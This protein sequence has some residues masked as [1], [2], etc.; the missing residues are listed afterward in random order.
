MPDYSDRRRQPLGKHRELFLQ[1]KA[2]RALSESEER[3]R[4]LV[5]LAPEAIVLL[6]PVS[7]HLVEAN[8]KAEEIFGCTRDELLSVALPQFYATDQPDKV[9]VS[10]SLPEHTRR[11]LAGEEV[12]F[13]RAIISAKGEQRY[14]EVRLTEFP[15]GERQL[16]LG[17]FIDISLRKRA[18]ESLKRQVRFN[19]LVTRHLTRFSSCVASEVDVCVTEALR[20]LAEFV[21]V[22]HAHVIMI[23]A[24]RKTW[25]ITHEWCGPGVQRQF[26]TYHNVPFGSIPWSESRILSGQPIRINTLDDYPPGAPERHGTDTKAG[27]TSVLLVPIRGPTGLITGAVGMDSHCGVIV[28]SADDVAHCEM[29][30]NAI[31]GVLERKNAEEL[32]RKSEEKFSK[33][34]EADPTITCILRLQ[35]RKYL[36]V[37]QA[38]ERR[39]GYSREEVIGRTG[40]DLGLWVNV[41]DR[42]VAFQRIVADRSVRGLEG[43]FRTKTKEPVVALLS[44]EIIEFEGEECVLVVAED[45]TERKRTEQAL[46][47]SE[48]RFRV[49]SDSAPVMM[50]MANPEKACTDFN[51]GWLE[52]TG[53][54][55]WQELGDG[56]TE[57]VHPA[58]LEKCART[59]IAAF[60]ERQRFT[61][62]Y[63][64]RRHD[65]VYRWI[66][67]TGVPRF[68][69]DGSF[70]GYIGCCI[71]INDQREAEKVRLEFAGRLMAAQEAERTRIAR[72]LH[73]SIG[74]SIAL[75]GIQMQR[76]DRPVSGASD[77]SHP[78]V[79]ALSGKL[80]EIGT[81]VSQLSHQLH[82]SELEFLGL[83]VAVKS[84]CRE[85][86]E[87]YQIAVNCLCISVP[88]KLDNDISLCF[89]RVTQEALHN[90]AK[91]SH[92]AR[93]Q[94]L[95]VGTSSR[96]ML[97]IRDDGMGFDV[98]RL[99][100]AAGLGLI[101]MRERLHLI[102]G[103][104]AISSEPAHGTRIEAH[105]P[106]NAIAI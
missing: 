6:D 32:L 21:G 56:W 67:D 4:T 82:S 91:H 11:V 86:S 8:R 53:R 10:E 87:E 90:I 25:S 100:P 37:N 79:Q 84:L 99:R 7:N 28:W 52:F 29:V 44:G 13:E 23:A 1:G 58:D 85:F 75:L 103:D 31:A 70:A 55:I 43:H 18:E 5:E 51:R 83:A 46:R 74:Q 36:A 69:P 19:D 95:L 15:S 59:Y 22:D 71:D 81:Q 76:A 62:E 64:L 17:S 94:V 42:E 3:F 16:I 50:W 33:V 54:T 88:D 73:D 40:I 80:Q 101:S 35:D 24:D 89:L 97:T 92:A 66:M 77:R 104:F 96:L 98:D 14:C 57:G 93:V 65:G 12:I 68:L 49:M 2:S 48:H 27:A 20:E 9:A 38:Y 105:A 63:R 41:E 26:S 39:T 61:M 102:G 47:E 78:S 106:L 30:G 72:E 45:I 60:D 34:F